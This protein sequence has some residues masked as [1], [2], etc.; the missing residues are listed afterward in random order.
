MEQFKNLYLQH[1]QLKNYSSYTIRQNEQY[2]RLFLNFLRTQ[3]INDINRIRLEIL[4][5]Y[6]KYLF[7]YKTC[8]KRSLSVLTING[9]LAQIRLFFQFLYKKGHIYSNP[10]ENLTLPKEPKQLPRGI[11]S[12]DEIKA[13]L[14]QPDIKTILGYRDRTILEVLY[15]T[16]IR[17]GELTRLKVSD[18]DFEKKL[19]R[20]KKGKGGKDRFVPL[21]TPTCRFLKRYINRIRSELS[22]CPRPCGN[23]WEERSKTGDGVLFLTSYNG[24][25]TSQWLAMVIKKYL[26][27]AGITRKVAPC[28]SFRHSIATHLLEDGMDIR[29]VQAFLGHENIQTTQVYTHVEKN[30]LKEMLLKFHPRSGASYGNDNNQ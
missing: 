23:N 20:I 7:F 26:K 14:N 5:E 10:A 22:Q 4:E 30:K 3:G 24:A 9:R 25:L 8:K 12:I 29:Y 27:K 15:S 21:N 17:A 2:L 16:G 13:I 6:K 19:L 18:T 1:I 11:M 28:H